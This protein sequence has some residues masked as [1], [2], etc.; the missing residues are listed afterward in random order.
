MEGFDHHL[1]P[2]TLCPAAEHPQKGPGTL[3]G[4]EGGWRTPPILTGHTHRSKKYVFNQDPKRLVE[5]PSL[6]TFPAPKEPDARFRRAGGSS[7]A[8]HS[9]L[10]APP[11]RLLGPDAA[12]KEDLEM[13][14]VRTEIV[15][16]R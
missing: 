7:V 16:R 5:C 4:A 2:P 6:P 1:R 14:D 13:S 9:P 10:W 3:E 11:L 15:L 8:S 12:P